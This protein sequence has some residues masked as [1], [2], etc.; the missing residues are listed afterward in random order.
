MMSRRKTST[1]ER[2]VFLILLL[3]KAINVTIFFLSGG[4]YIIE[5]SAE[6]IHAWKIESQ[7]PA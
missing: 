3:E 2:C 5:N 1:L 6:R 7:F 4:S